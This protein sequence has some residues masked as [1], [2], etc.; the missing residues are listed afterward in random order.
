MRVSVLG[1]GFGVELGHVV[2]R[3]EASGG[4]GSGL[5][6]A[7]GTGRRVTS[8]PRSRIM[9]GPSARAKERDDVKRRSKTGEVLLS[10]HQSWRRKGTVVWWSTRKRTCFA[11]TSWHRSPRRP[12]TP[13]AMAARHR[14]RAGPA[15]HPISCLGSNSF[16][17]ACMSWIS[18]LAPARARGFY[19]CP[20]SLRRIVPP[21]PPPC[22]SP[23]ALPPHQGTDPSRGVAAR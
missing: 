6:G 7:T 1:E 17:I 15:R 21:S 3:G 16:A 23:I 4:V 2:G 18:E 12:S 8:A 11:R 9:R 22:A 13:V 19:S 14:R 5:E 10:T 20:S